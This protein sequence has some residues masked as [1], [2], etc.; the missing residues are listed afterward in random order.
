MRLRATTPQP[1]QQLLDAPV[2]RVPV[3]VD[4]RLNVRVAQ[5]LLDEVDRLAGSQP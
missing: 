3:L 4:R 1:W 2:C 5:L